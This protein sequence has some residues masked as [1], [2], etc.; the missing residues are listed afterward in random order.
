M[1]CVTS[2]LKR[3]ILDYSICRITEFSC[4]FCCVA[5]KLCTWL[6]T[7]INKLFSFILF[8]ALMPTFFTC[9]FAF[10]IAWIAKR[11]NLSMIH[12]RNS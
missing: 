10:F 11:L 7:N 5:L 2:S 12:N 4:F 3:V 8:I 6:V 1:Q 9:L